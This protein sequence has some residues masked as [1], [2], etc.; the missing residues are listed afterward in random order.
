MPCLALPYRTPPPETGQQLTRRERKQFTRTLADLVRLV[1]MFP[2]VIIPGAEL[3]LPFAIKIFPNMLPTQF[4]HADTE[5]KKQRAN[6]R[7]RYETKLRNAIPPPALFFVKAR[8]PA[9]GG[10]RS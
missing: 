9:W 3:L 10:G 8:T 6:L 7:V 4:R 2:F 5:M 1:P